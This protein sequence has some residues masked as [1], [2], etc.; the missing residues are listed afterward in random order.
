MAMLLWFATAGAAPVEYHEYQVKAVWML[1]FT[2]FV[3]WPSDAFATKDSPCVIGIL[4]KSPF[5]SE[6]EAAFAGKTTKG[7]PIQMTGVLRE[8][9]AARCHVLFVPAG[10]RRTWNEVRTKLTRAPLLVISEAE[11]SLD[12]GSIIN[13]IM[14]DGSVAFEI[15]L[16]N[17]QN[18]RLKFDANLLKIAAK[19]KGKYE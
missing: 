16:K 4:G 2:R 9:E 6:L 10:E 14:R 13:F 17:A 15:N 19:V 18:S 8:T 11:D 12:Q 1:N 7:R 5:G 3:E